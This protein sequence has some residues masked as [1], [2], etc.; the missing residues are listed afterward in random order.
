MEE[1]GRLND[2]G[3]RDRFID[4]VAA[5]SRWKEYL[6]T[7]GTVSGLQNFHA[8]HKY[9]LMAHSPKD[10]HPLG[11]IAAKATEADIK[12]AQSEYLEIL[13]SALKVQ[14]TVRKNTNVLQ[15]IAGYF[16]KELE[17]FEKNEL[18]KSIEEY[19]QENF[20]L[21]ATLVLLQH[22][23]KKYDKHY[24]LEQYYL[25]PSPMELYLKYHV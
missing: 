22:F 19:H 1:E 25:S 20:P 13:I 9:M 8:R 3:L 24:L 18:Q 5:Y 16:K 11:R 10:V 7:A 15:H 4:H 21:L 14:A 2:P 12:K 6:K 17:V 23:A